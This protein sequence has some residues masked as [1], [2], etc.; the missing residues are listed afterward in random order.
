MIESWCVRVPKSLGEPARRI[1]YRRGELVATLKPRVVGDYVA[2][3]V[4]SAE[5][6]SSILLSEGIEAEPCRDL[7]E[8][9][10]R[11]RAGPAPRGYLV[12]GDIVLFS[13]RREELEDLREAA[14]VVMESQPRVKAAFAK[15]RVEGDYR[16]PSLVHL[17]GEKRTWTL[18]KEHGLRFYVD[19]AKAYFN[20]RLAYEHRR[21]ASMASDGERVLDMFSGVGG[22]SLHIASLA[23]ARVL[24]VDLNPY[25]AAYAAI[26]VALNRRR[27]RGEVLVL[28]ADASRL[29]SILRGGF[30]RIIMNHPTASVKYLGHAC[31][32]AA[33]GAMAHVYVFSLSWLEARDTVLEALEASSCGA[34]ILGVR[35]VLEYSQDT[36]L[37]ALDVRLIGAP[38][39]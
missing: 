23:R 8:E 18:H 36:S 31:R 20:P 7:F 30:T 3:P 24:A 26:N 39:A 27:L 22:F 34:E 6:A 2:Y 11:A 1:L 9:Y 14:R 33:D 19:I 29:P 12:V 38:K 28:R 10:R 15:V 25:A 5:R 13:G 21:V 32:L 4:A 16:R 17:A 35:E 37:Y